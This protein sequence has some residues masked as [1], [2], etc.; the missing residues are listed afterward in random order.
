MR[1][2][3]LRECRVRHGDTQQDLADYLG[4][5]V[6]AVAN[7]EN[8]RRE[9]NHRHLSRMAQRYNVS[10]DYLAGITDDPARYKDLPP[11]WE[12]VFEEAAKRHMSPEMVAELI[13]RVGD[14]LAK[15][16]GGQD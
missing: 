1:G 14:L 11:G 9:P 16:N 2:D 8:N 12:Q 15:K 6:H 10:A 13:R 5:T 3:R 4:V 7:W